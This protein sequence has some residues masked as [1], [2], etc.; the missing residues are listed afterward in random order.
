MM[1]GKRYTDELKIEA[2]KQVTAN[3]YKIAEAAER[4]GVS[5]KKYA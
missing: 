2:V 4:L 5:Y 1:S 3:G